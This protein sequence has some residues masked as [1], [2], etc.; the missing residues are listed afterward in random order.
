VLLEVELAQGSF[1]HVFESI[2]VGL[3]MGA[4]ANPFEKS[5]E[6]YDMIYDAT[7]KDYRKEAS[8]IH[9]LIRAHK[10]SEGNSLLDVACGTGRHIQYMRRCYSCEGLDLQPKLLA[11]ARKRNRNV[12]FHRGNMLAFNL[13]KNFDVITC[14]FSAIGYMR[15]I[16]ELRWAMRSMASHLKPGGV[17]IVEPW[18]TPDQIIPGHVGGVFVNQPKFKLA[19]MNIVDVKGRLSIIVF[20][21]LLGRPQGVEYFTELDEFGL[22]THNEYLAAF[23][24][25]GLNVKYYRKGL[26]GRGLYI[27]V[28][29]TSISGI[30]RQTQDHQTVR[31]KS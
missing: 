16:R 3:A 19:R 11:R 2:V 7:G 1:Q 31:G 14:L 5:A 6:Y 15:N 22:F 29:P 8:R 28:R 10:R 13:H 25:A 12:V 26:I 17:L 30:Q 9:Q 23:R 24:A 18:L 4:H 21:Y 20:H 27:G